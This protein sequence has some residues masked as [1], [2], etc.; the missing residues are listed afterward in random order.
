MDV[1]A[2][3]SQLTARANLALLLNKIR[4]ETS[5]LRSTLD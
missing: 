3:Y 5:R 2:I 4:S 1:C